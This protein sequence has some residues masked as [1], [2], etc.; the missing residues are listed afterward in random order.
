M[1]QS[2]AAAGDV[3]LASAGFTCPAGPLELSL[4]F[5]PAVGE[6]ITLVENTP[7]PA[8][9]GSP[10]GGAFSN[11]APGATAAAVYDGLAYFFSVTYSG[12]GGGDDLVLTAL[13]TVTWTGGAGTDNW[14][15]AANWSSDA[16][17]GPF[18]QVVI[19]AT[20]PLTIVHAAGNDTIYSLT[21]SDSLAVSISRAAASPCSRIR[22]ST[23]P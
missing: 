4:D 20:G 3:A 1:L 14:R 9:A 15:D 13:S 16:V 18:D 23:A 21:S 7:T 19:G 11:L 2:S 17:P 22:S 5:A 12:G 10:I 8:T 6:Q